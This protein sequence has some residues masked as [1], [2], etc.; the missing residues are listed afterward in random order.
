LAE[1]TETPNDDTTNKGGSLLSELT[2]LVMPL[3]CPFCGATPKDSGRRSTPGEERKPDME[4]VHWYVC[5]CGGYGANAHRMAF[6]STP[7]QARKN[8]LTR[9]NVRA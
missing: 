3:P 9:W 2:G 6:G 4:F 8:A 5:F 7:D 1:R